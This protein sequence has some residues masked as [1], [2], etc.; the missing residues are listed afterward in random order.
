VTIL[1]LDNY[2]S[3]TYNLYDYLRQAGADCVV[4]RN[5][6]PEL[7]AFSPEDFDAV[8]L[9]PG[10]KRPEDAGLMPGLIRAWHDRLPILG[11]CLGHQ[12]LGAFFG[13]EVV[14]AP[15]PMHGKTS[16]VQHGGHPLFSGIPQY[17][18]VMRYH[19]LIVEGLEGTP[20]VGIARTGDGTIMALAHEQ[21]PLLGVQFHPESI[22]TDFGYQLLENWINLV[23]ESGPGQ[24]RNRVQPA[25][26]AVILP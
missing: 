14:P 24:S 18:S 16:E 4:V 11:I 26:M 23:R 10:P 20:L 2:D 25:H 13:A 19:S 3:F 9:S 21:L 5:D 8:V 17:F 6:S 15:V 7:A 1:L 22:L 12:A